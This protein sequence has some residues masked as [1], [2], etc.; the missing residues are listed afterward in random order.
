MDTAVE[1]A[2]AYLRTKGLGVDLKALHVGILQPSRLLGF[3]AGYILSSGIAWVIEEP[4]Q[5]CH[6]ALV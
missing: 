5:F 3:S 4:S 6:G 1:C 2:E